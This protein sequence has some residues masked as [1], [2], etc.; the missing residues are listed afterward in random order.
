MRNIET[1]K[2]ETQMKDLVI[3]IDSRSLCNQK[4]GYIRHSANDG[5]SNI[6]LPMNIIVYVPSHI[7]TLDTILKGENILSKSTRRAVVTFITL[8]ASI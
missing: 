1:S 8:L 2:R 6:T 5:F 3:M 4:W 7:D